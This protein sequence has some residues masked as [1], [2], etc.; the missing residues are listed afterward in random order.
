MKNKFLLSYIGKVQIPSR[1]IQPQS[2][3]LSYQNYYKMVVRKIS[4]KSSDGRENKSQDKKE[5]DDS[6]I[7]KGN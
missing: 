4:N 3:N 7:R 5:L 6:N 2:C 1:N